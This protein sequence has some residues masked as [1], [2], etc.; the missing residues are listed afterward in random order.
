MIVFIINVNL[1]IITY[2]I[3]VQS[4]IELSKHIIMNELCN[5]SELN[6]TVLRFEQFCPN[7]YY[8]YNIIIIYYKFFRLNVL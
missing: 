2:S 8:K 4:N 5:S 7:K 3:R 6:E 1:D